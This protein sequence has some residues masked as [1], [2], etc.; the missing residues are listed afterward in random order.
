MTAPLPPSERLR[1]AHLN[2]RAPTVFDLTPDADRCAAIAAELGISALSRLTFSGEIRAE[3][4]DGWALSGRLRARVTQPC[5]V[6]LKPVKTTLDEAVA[7]HYS[8]HLATPEGD[9][10]EMP[11]DTLEPLG[12]FIDLAAVMIEELA[13]ALPPYPRADGAEF[14]AAPEVPAPDTRRPFEGLDKLL[15]HRDDD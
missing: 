2:P 11:D 9:E 3:S 15:R 10:V 14:E 6:T 4:G 8:P 5:V 12:Q 1:V 13:L 7:R